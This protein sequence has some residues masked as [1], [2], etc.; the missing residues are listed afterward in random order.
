MALLTSGQAAAA[1]AAAVAQRD[2]IQA[3]LLELDDSFGKRLLAGA[4][5]TGQTRERWEA[6]AASLATL[7][8]TFTAYSTVVDR[9]VGVL[10]R[11]HRPGGPELAEVTTL[12][13]LPSVQVARAS[14]PL[15]RRQLTAERTVEFTLAGAVAD[16]TLAFTTVSGMVSAAETVWNAV[17][18]RL[19][20]AEAELGTARREAAGLADA[21]LAEALAMAES[22]LRELREVL[23]HDPLVLWQA[24]T[25]DTARAGRLGE[26]VGVAVARARELAGLREAAGSRIAQASRAVA[27]AQEAWDDAVAA[28]QRTVSRVAAV[29]LSP[30]PDVPALVSRLAVLERLRLA[31][32]WSRLEAELD[33]IDE[34]A[35][36][37]ARQCHDAERTAVALLDRRNELRG[38]LDAYRARA[39]RL[40]AAENAEVSARYEEA[41]R[42]LWTAP[43]DLRA[44]TDAVTYFQQAVRGIAG[45]EERP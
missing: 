17:A 24:G 22:D 21:T 12:L 10:P 36:A 8:E 4:A 20:Q 30:P 40:G 18:G 7:W 11:A 25:A 27:A 14:P 31:G 23:N 6:A 34:Q 28:Q 29:S 3:N 38:L 39:L 35:G 9:A 16:M 13:T 26:R 32:R 43:C 19:Q 33:L 45:Q 41:R 42:L 44:A 37:C 2:T 1:V 5:L 15:G